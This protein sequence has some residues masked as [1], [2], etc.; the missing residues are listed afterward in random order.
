MNCILYNVQ[1]E[2]DSCGYY[3]V[4]D[5]M[6]NIQLTECEECNSGTM[7]PTEIVPESSVEKK[8]VLVDMLDSVCSELDENRKG[9]SGFRDALQGIRNGIDKHWDYFQENY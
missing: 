5:F 7:M 1:M 4:D 3:Y 6:G 2:C 8:D 9:E